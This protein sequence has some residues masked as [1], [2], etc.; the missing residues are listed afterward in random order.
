MTSVD[1][2]FLEGGQGFTESGQP[3]HEFDAPEISPEEFAEH[4]ASRVAGALEATKMFGVVEVRA[5]VG[6]VNIMGRVK[7]E[8]E[9]RWAE[10]VVYPMLLVIEKSED[11][12]GFIGKQYLLKEGKSLESMKYAWVISF[13]SN[14][15]RKS[16]SDIC[17]SFEAAVPRVEVTE[18]PLMGPGTPQ[19][20]GQRSGRKGASP[21]Y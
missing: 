19:S 8:H 3:V 10:D 17:S 12:N 21:V 16:A 7:R 6:Q 13:A 1:T 15:L 18:S 14:D 20:G 2:E 4:I 9:R 5:G 11:C